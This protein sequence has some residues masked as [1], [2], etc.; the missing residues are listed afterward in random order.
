VSALQAI[1]PPGATLQDPQR[2]TAVWSIRLEIDEI[3]EYFHTELDEWMSG[4][5]H[6][7][8]TIKDARAKLIGLVQR[9]NALEAL[10]PPSERALLQLLEEQI[11][12]A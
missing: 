6:Y 9:V 1:S 11:A 4:R 7:E 5:R 3:L 10:G 2:T 12:A 8:I